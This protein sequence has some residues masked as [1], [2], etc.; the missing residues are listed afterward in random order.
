MRFVILFCIFCLSR[1]NGLNVYLIRVPVRCQAVL[2]VAI[3]SSFYHA[4]IAGHN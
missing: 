1:L 3:R 4:E 2:L